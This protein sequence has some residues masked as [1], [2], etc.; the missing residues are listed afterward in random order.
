V[1]PIHFGKGPADAF[2]F[3]PPV[4]EARF[5]ANKS[6]ARE[7]RPEILSALK[8]GKHVAIDFTNAVYTTQSAIHALLHEPIAQLGLSAL[9]NLHF[10]RTSPQV[11]AVIRLVTNYALSQ[12]DPS[13]GN[14]E[15]DP[16]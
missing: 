3:I 16:E 5:A 4:D 7:Q 1:I 9:S 11:A 14:A 8:N 13:V 6:W 2:I 10:V 12:P 15:E